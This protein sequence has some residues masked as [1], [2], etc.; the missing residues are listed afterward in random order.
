M[1]QS[2]FELLRIMA[3]FAIVLHHLIVNA[4]NVVGYNNSFVDNFNNDTLL[5]I[6]SMLVGG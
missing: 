4:I 6:N 1:R 3:M 5:V 2:N